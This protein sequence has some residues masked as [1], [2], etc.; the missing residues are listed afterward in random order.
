MLVA[1]GAGWRFGWVAAAVAALAFAACSSFG[2]SGGGGG[3][4][5][6]GGTDG[7]IGA[8][9]AGAAIDATSSRYAASVLADEPIAYYRL[10]EPAGASMVSPTT[11]A[12]TGLL[13][14]GGAALGAPGATSDGD[15][16][17]ALDGG[18]SV[19]FGEVFDFDGVKPF[20]YEAWAKLD[21]DDDS[22][23]MLFSKDL[24]DG[25][26]QWHIANVFARNG[27][28]SFERYVSADVRVVSSGHVPLGAYLH[29]AAVYDGASIRLYVDGQGGTPLA[30][31]RPSG[32]KTGASFLVGA[33]PNQASWIGAVD[34]VAIYDK[35]LTREQILA[36]VAAR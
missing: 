29:V 20:T 19:E 26:K 36:H 32:P 31:E 4:G 11:G 30:D 1:G 7:G 12:V 22:Y 9:D 23:R 18:G 10:G 8:G 33:G 28:L 5:S 27:A 25:G 15:T 34:E 35:A 24:H 21:V 2:E 3:G 13:P 6:S 17:L 14:L 16:A